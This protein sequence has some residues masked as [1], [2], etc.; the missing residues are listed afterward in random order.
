M[1]KRRVAA[2]KHSEDRRWREHVDFNAVRAWPCRRIAGGTPQQKLFPSHSQCF[3]MKHDHRAIRQ[4]V[5]R[6]SMNPLTHAVQS[7]GMERMVH[8]ASRGAFFLAGEQQ[9][10]LFGIFSTALEARTVTCRK[11]RDLVEKKQ[12]RVAIAPN[13][14][15]PTLELESAADPGPGDPTARCELSLRIM[16]PPA[17]IAHQGSSARRRNQF[18]KRRYA[19]WQGHCR[20]SK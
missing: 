17:A 16:Q 12:F 5:D 19:V 18:S 7:L 15:M 20:S 4:S 6:R 9:C 3:A 14:A 8:D 11:R 2:L 13:V 1:P 10:K